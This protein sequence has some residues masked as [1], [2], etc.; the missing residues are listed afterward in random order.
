MTRV[1]GKHR[2]HPNHPCV[3]VVATVVRIG[4][5]TVLRAVLAIV[6]LLIAIA[7]LIVAVALIVTALIVVALCE[8]AR[9]G[10][11]QTQRECGNKQAFHSS[12]PFVGSK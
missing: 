1:I 11:E 2:I 12:I 6:V 4:V 7:R 5:T 3:V 8:S 10:R 9:T